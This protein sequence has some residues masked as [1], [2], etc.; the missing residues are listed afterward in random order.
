MT[1]QFET[2]QFYIGLAVIGIF[3]GIGSA[4]GQYLFNDWL[5]KHFLSKAENVLNF[6]KKKFRRL[7]K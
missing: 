1:L 4:L 7:K 6:G 2:W 3:S 5:K